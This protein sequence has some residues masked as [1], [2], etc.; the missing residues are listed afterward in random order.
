M[1]LPTAQFQGVR[2]GKRLMREAGSPVLLATGALGRS[3]LSTSALRS[4]E[5]AEW[6]ELYYR[7]EPLGGAGVSVCYALGWRISEGGG[8]EGTTLRADATTLA[9]TARRWW[10]QRRALLRKYGQLP[11]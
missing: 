7:E 10:K 1:Q 8:F 5:Y 4:G 2:I 3:H 9:A 6:R 11:E